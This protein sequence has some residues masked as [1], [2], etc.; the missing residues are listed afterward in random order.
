MKIKLEKT[1]HSFYCNDSNYYV[2]GLNN[3]GL[4]EYDS[5][6]EFKEDWLLDDLTIDHDYNHC[7]RFDIKEKYD[8]E[9]DS[10]ISGEY[11]LHLYFMLQRKGNFVPV[12]INTIVEDEMNEVNI[13]L[14]QCWEYL[15][16][17]WVELQ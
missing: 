2:N 17:Q 7:F 5:W 13:Y 11:S 10:E 16:K 9:T 12:R 14:K 8:H 4:A 15:K 1:N 3:F 6:S